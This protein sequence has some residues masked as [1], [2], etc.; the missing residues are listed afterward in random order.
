MFGHKRK[1]KEPTSKRLGS[2]KKKRSGGL[3]KRRSKQQPCK[4]PDGLGQITTPNVHDY[5]PNDN[6]NQ[7]QKPSKLHSHSTSEEFKYNGNGLLS[8]IQ[9]TRP[10]SQSVLVVS[11]G[12]QMGNYMG[13]IRRKQ[14]VASTSEFGSKHEKLMNRLKV[15]AKSRMKSIEQDKEILNYVQQAFEIHDD[16]SLNN[17][18]HDE[19]GQDN[20]IKMTRSNTMNYENANGSSPFSMGG[21]GIKKSQT[22]HFGRDEIFGKKKKYDCKVVSGKSFDNLLDAIEFMLKQLWDNDYT[23]SLYE[24]LVKKISLPH[25]A[26]MFSIGVERKN[27]SYFLKKYQNCFVGSEGVDWLI[28]AKFV[29]DTDDKRE[30]AKDLGN[31]F[32]TRGFLKHVAG[33]HKFKDEKL[34]YTFDDGLIDK[35]CLI[36]DNASF[37]PSRPTGLTQSQSDSQFIE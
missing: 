18:D 32:Q 27:R 24:Q 14:S 8:P 12:M 11:N 20:N 30:R 5:N 19:N 6:N 23:K 9:S 15:A 22:I 21:H 7:Q 2:S 33:Q 31:S 26:K 17:D 34:W 37:K 36:E 13:D 28:R 10:S 3:F 29:R 25:K 4:T 1:D 35:Q 16:N